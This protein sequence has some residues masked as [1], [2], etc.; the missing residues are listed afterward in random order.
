VPHQHDIA[1][2][3]NAQTRRNFPFVIVLQSDRA[4]SVGSLI[5][6]PLEQ[7]HGAFAQSRIHPA[8]EVDGVPYVVLCERMAAVPLT[9]LGRVVGSGASS[10]YEIA[11]AL[12]V[13]FT[14]I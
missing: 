3:R 10:R 5:V 1:E 4:A 2:K 12:D 13:L 6:P 7:S 8:V 9:T 14:G 11:A